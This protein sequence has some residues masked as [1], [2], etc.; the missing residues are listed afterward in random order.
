M[1]DNEIAAA[2]QPRIYT[3]TA[4]HAEQKCIVTNYHHFNAIPDNSGWRFDLPSDL[5]VG[6]FYSDAGDFDRGEK[7]IWRYVRE[8]WGRKRSDIKVSRIISKLF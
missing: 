6:P 4:Y 1:H 3:V 2:D 8:Q 5:G 7:E